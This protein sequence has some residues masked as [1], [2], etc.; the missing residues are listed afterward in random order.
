MLQHPRACQRAFLG[1]VAHQEDCR[2]TLLGIAHQQRRT[3]T[4]LRHPARG[5]LQLFGED[6]L[7]GVDHHYPWLFLTGGG[8]DG[9]DAGFGHDLE[10]VLGK[11]QTPGAHG[12]L[13]LR[14]L[15]GDVQRRHADGDVA[16]GL[17]QDRR[18]ADPRVATDQDHGAIDQ[19]TA[20]HTVELGAAGGEARD[21]LDADLSQGLDLRLLPRPAGAARAGGCGAAALDHGFDQRVPGATLATLASPFRKSRAALGAAIQA[22]GLGHG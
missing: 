4:H 1:H 13:L 12:H 17:Q 3:F 18:F 5:G 2:A 20:Q 22:L 19:A 15:A 16:Q 7:D 10:L 8:D 21:L 6:G 11:A 9:F 14:L